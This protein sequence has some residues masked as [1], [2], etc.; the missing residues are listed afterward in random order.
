[1]KSQNLF[2]AKN[3]KKYH[4]YVKFWISP[5][6][7]KGLQSTGMTVHVNQ[8]WYMYASA[9][10]FDICDCIIIITFFSLF[11]KQPENICKSSRHVSCS[12]KSNYKIVVGV[13]DWVAIIMSYTKIHSNA[14]K[15]SLYCSFDISR[16]DVFCLVFYFKWKYFV[17]IDHILSETICLFCFCVLLSI[18]YSKIKFTAKNWSDPCTFY[19]KVIF[20]L[21]FV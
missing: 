6:N 11:N 8:L 15:I 14:F 1:M 4:E 10:H 5:D 9:G 12:L 21:F 16:K 17:L 20:F 2:S 3:K 18:F 19:S 7:G 13:F